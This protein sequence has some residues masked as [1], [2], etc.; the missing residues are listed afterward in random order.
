LGPQNRKKSDPGR[1]LRGSGEKGQ[2]KIRGGTDPRW[3]ILGEDVQRAS[4]PGQERNNRAGGMDNPQSGGMREKKKKKRN[5][6]K[7]K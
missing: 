1:K 3:G 6:K 7:K 5:Q 4:S 2:F